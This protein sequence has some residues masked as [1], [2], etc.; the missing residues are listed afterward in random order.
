MK[1]RMFAAVRRYEGVADPAAAAVQVN[2]KFVPLISLL[3]GFIEYYWIDLNG[4]AML[5]ITVFKTLA[6]AIAAN[7]KASVWV[8]DHLSSVLPPASRMEVGAI[9][10]HKEEIEDA[11]G[12]HGVWKRKLKKAIT[13]GEIDV[14]IA[15]IKADKQCDFG[16]WLYGPAITERHKNSEHYREVQELHAVFHETAAKVAQLAISGEKAHAMKMLEANGEFT[17]ASA[18][19]TTSMI[20]WL[21]DGCQ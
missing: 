20:A 21:K 14:D 11:V 8:K 16:K 1:T 17:V 7:E 4:G 9:V 12:A 5:S 19:L 2:E 18:E 3:P 6:D 10:A 15:T 13:T